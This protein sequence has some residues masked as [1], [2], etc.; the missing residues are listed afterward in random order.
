MK[1]I[2]RGIFHLCPA[3]LQLM[4]FN[5]IT[6]IDFYFMIFERYVFICGAGRIITN[7]LYMNLCVTRAHRNCMKS[8]SGVS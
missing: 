1:L 2:W 6:I 5:L 4:K 8:N 3:T 7:S